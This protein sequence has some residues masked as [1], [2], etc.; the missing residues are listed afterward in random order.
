MEINIW[1]NAPI[2][3]KSALNKHTEA[4]LKVATCSLLKAKRFH[5]I[6]KYKQVGNSIAIK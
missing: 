2:E 1:G 5:Y 3:L 4:I 6:C